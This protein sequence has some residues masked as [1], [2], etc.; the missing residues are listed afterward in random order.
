MSVFLETAE[1]ETWEYVAD[2]F[3]PD[4]AHRAAYRNTSSTAQHPHSRKSKKHRKQMTLHG[5]YHSKTGLDTV[6]KKADYVCIYITGSSSV[7]GGFKVNVGG[8]TDGKSDHQLEVSGVV[9]IGVS[10]FAVEIELSHTGP[11]TAAQA[12]APFA[13]LWAA[14]RRFGA[15]RIKAAKGAFA[16]SETNDE[17]LA[18]IYKKIDEKY[19]GTLQSSMLDEADKYLTTFWTKLETNY[20]KK[21]V[22]ESSSFKTARGKGN[23]AVVEYLTKEVFSP[24][25]KD[26]FPETVNTFGNKLSNV[27]SSSVKKGNGFEHLLKRFIKGGYFSPNYYDLKSSDMKY[28]SEVYRSMFP[29]TFGTLTECDFAG[30]DFECY[31]G[32]LHEM[33]KKKIDL[34][35]GTAAC[36]KDGT[37]LDFCA[38]EWRLGHVAE[39]LATKDLPGVLKDLEDFSTVPAAEK[40]PLKWDELTVGIK[41]VI[42]NSNPSDFCAAGNTALTIDASVQRTYKWNAG[43]KSWKFDHHT[44]QI[45]GNAHIELPFAC[46]GGKSKTSGFD[47]DIHWTIEKEK[48]VVEVAYKLMVP[49][50]VPSVG[51]VA[52]AFPEGGT[53]AKTLRS[54][55]TL[56]ANENLHAALSTAVAALGKAIKA[57]IKLFSGNSKAKRKETKFVQIYED[58]KKSIK[59]VVAAFN[60][61]SIKKDGKD[62]ALNLFDGFKQVTGADIASGIINYFLPSDLT[63][64]YL[65]FEIGYSLYWDPAKKDFTLIKAQLFSHSEVQTKAEIL[66]DKI[67]ALYVQ[68]SGGQVVSIYLCDNGLNEKCDAEIKQFGNP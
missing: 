42:S 21:V 30:M 11:C 9:T 6:V 56:A 5:A 27:F 31:A 51:G 48:S 1:E 17:K 2:L 47:M 65:G 18:A 67:G 44:G 10:V 34:K 35:G 26:T 43:E 33:K 59:D 64:S 57:P 12:D 16:G 39:I 37:S 22:K 3:Y 53:I 28:L 25:F 36:I 15:E 13:T 61:V 41:F 23:Q 54:T 50:A 20:D 46:D 62:V 40:D 24:A 38:S 19:G 63:V 55:S 66:K 49:Y 4:R 58:S 7:W 45:H 8:Y 60:K 14:M 68:Q 29:D 52:L 32:R